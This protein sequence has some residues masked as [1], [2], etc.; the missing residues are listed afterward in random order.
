MAK[1]AVSV[2]CS[3]KEPGLSDE[4]EGV[5]ILDENAPIGVP[6]ADYLGDAVLDISILPNVARA[7]S[8]LGVARE[9]AA[10]CPR[11]LPIS[12]WICSAC[13]EPSAHLSIQANRSRRHQ[14]IFRQRQEL[15]TLIGIPVG[16]VEA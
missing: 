14:F 1:C 4:H 11:G 7:T 8:T 2:V 10:L 5:I 9:V 13:G 12:R 6:A 15:W 16:M 3:E